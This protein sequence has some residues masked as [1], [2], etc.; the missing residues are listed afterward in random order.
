VTDER[1]RIVVLNAANGIFKSSVDS[2]HMAGP[3]TALIVK[4]IANKAAKN[5]SSLASHTIVPTAT[6]LGRVIF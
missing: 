4:Y 1:T 5:M 2:A 6:A 3:W